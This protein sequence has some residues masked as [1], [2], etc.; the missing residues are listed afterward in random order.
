[1]KEAD[2]FV[3]AFALLPWVT[4]FKLGSTFRVKGLHHFN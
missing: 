1:M 3:F 4:N 2:I